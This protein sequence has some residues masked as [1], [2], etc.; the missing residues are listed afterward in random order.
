MVWVSC[1]RS[2]VIIS[3]SVLLT[4]TYQKHLESANLWFN[5]HH[6]MLVLKQLPTEGIRK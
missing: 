4:K 1:R 3:L 6:D 2:A 5:L